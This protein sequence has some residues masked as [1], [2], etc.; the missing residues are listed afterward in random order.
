MGKYGTGRGAR[1]SQFLPFAQ[2]F[3]S[4]GHVPNRHSV[5]PEWNKAAAGSRATNAGPAA[6]RDGT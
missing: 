5:V 6:G 1:R 3:V 2:R 4:S